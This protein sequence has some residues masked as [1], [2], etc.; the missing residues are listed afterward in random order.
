MIPLISSS[1]VCFFSLE[2]ISWNIFLYWPRTFLL[3]FLHFRWIMMTFLVKSYNEIWLN[4]R[5][6]R[7]M[8]GWV[9]FLSAKIGTSSCIHLIIL[10]S[11]LLIYSFKLLDWAEEFAFLSLVIGWL[12][13]SY[14]PRI[15]MLSSFET[16]LSFLINVEVDWVLFFLGPGGACDKA[17]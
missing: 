4:N 17:C 2:A 15:L 6:L 12:P 5:I 3:D 13:P 14:D 7:M 16:T 1:F 10:I 11:M 8:S 9:S